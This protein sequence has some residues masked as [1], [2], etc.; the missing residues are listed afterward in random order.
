[1]MVS[2]AERVF[3]GEGQMIHE[4]TRLRL[5]AFMNGFAAFVSSGDKLCF[6]RS[7]I[8]VYI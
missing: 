2:N 7:E 3:D 5:E 1:M 6:A 4:K 8:D